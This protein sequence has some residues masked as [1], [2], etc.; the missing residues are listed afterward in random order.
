MPAEL[1]TAVTMKKSDNETKYEVGVNWVEQYR[2]TYSRAVDGKN[3]LLLLKWI[4]ENLG[5]T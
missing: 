3:V 4:S 2:Q 5:I 1:W